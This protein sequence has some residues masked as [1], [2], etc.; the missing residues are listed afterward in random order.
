MVA[1]K[2]LKQ[3]QGR[4]E[5]AN[6]K[7]ITDMADEVDP[8]E[9]QYVVKLLDNFEHVSELGRYLCLVLEAMWQDSESFV[10]GLS[11]E[12]RIVVVQRIARQLVRGVDLLHKCGIMHNGNVKG[13]A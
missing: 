10:K 3:G 6:L 2:V 1:L 5:L 11:D 7:R 8:D 13:S 4:E 12:T 9:G